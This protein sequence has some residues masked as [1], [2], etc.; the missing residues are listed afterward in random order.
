MR[1]VSQQS[2]SHFSARISGGRSKLIAE[3]TGKVRQSDLGACEGCARESSA[4]RKG[5]IGRANGGAKSA[6]LQ[7]CGRHDVDVVTMVVVR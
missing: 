5:R 1:S 2:I 4:L 7:E 6:L 3:R